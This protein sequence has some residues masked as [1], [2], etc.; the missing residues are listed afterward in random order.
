[1]VEL[2]ALEVMEL[3]ALEMVALDALEVVALV[4]LEVDHRSRW[5]PLVWHAWP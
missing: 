3:G 2:D 4:A 1:M 5:C